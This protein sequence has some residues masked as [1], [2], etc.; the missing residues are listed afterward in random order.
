MNETSISFVDSEAGAQYRCLLPSARF[1]RRTSLKRSTKSNDGRLSKACVERPRA[2]SSKAI[3]A[4]WRRT[5]S[6]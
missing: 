3:A 1:P 2:I 4:D 5:A 6:R